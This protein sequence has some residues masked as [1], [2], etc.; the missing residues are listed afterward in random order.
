VQIVTEN[1]KTT[2]SRHKSYVNNRRRKLT[3]EV[4]DYVY[5]NVSP[6]SGMIKV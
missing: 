4:G 1:M 3:F 5:V 6:M 2:Q